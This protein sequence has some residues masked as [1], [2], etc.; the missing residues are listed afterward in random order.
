[1]FRLPKRRELD[2]GRSPFGNRNTSDEGATIT[3]H[4]GYTRPWGGNSLTDLA[5]ESRPDA[6]TCYEAFYWPRGICR[7]GVSCKVRV[8]VA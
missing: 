3:L 7:T 8:P 2:F 6:A 4:T 1:M 5:D